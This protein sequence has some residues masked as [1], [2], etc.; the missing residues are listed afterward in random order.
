LEI[1]EK[2][3]MRFGLEPRANSLVSTADGFLRMWDKLL[4]ERFFCVL[5]V[6][7][8]AYH[9]ESVPV[10]IKK[11]GS[12]LGILQI[13]GTDGET[14][15]HL[16]MNDDLASRDTLRHLKEAN[17]KGIVDVELYGMPTEAIDESYHQAREILERQVLALN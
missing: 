14:L 13:C 1:A 16:P 9:R 3:Q 2:H 10:A 8:C 11:L 17:F 15:S 7:H 4:S 5:D 12:R 6:M